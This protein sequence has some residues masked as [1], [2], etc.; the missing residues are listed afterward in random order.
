MTTKITIAS[1]PES[2]GD[3]VLN[4]VNTVQGPILNDVIRP[5][6]SR[7]LWITSCSMLAITERHPRMIPEPENIAMGNGGAITNKCGDDGALWA[8]E[9]VARNPGVGEDAARAWFQ[10]AIEA[11]CAV[12]YERRQVAVGAAIANDESSEAI[13]LLALGE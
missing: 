4:A 11:A 13:L 2:N 10:N 12:R 6:E 8:H 7:E 5:G 9:F 3:V 1:A